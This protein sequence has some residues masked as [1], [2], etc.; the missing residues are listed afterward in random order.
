MRVHPFDADAVCESVSLGGDPHQQVQAC[1]QT[2]SSAALK[3][4]HHNSALIAVGTYRE[5]LHDLH[6]KII[7]NLGGPVYYSHNMA[8]GRQEH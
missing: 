2:E 7:P 6:E 3:R 5:D 1:C 4:K 8:Q